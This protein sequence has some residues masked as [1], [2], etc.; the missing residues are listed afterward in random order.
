MLRHCIRRVLA[1][2]RPPTASPSSRRMLEP[3]TGDR[4]SHGSRVDEFRTAKLRRGCPDIC[5][6]IWQLPIAS[7]QDLR[8]AT[9]LQIDDSVT[10]PFLS[11]LVSWAALLFFGS[12][13]LARLNT[14]AVFTLAIGALSVASAI[15]L[16]LELDAPYS[17]MLRLPPTPI[18]QAIDALAK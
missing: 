2:R 6:A 9:R 5:P 11:I 4:N 12:G 18:L 14:A 10:W 1:R 16:I 17:G 15:F 13:L 7:I 8:L 3:N